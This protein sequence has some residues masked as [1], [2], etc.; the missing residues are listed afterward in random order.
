MADNINNINSC[1]DD[2]EKRVPSPIDENRLKE[3][4]AMEAAEQ[5]LIEDLFSTCAKVN[6]VANVKAQSNTIPV[7]SQKK[8]KKKPK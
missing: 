6:A 7:S 4:K 3:I 2:A 5:R 8:P 1:D